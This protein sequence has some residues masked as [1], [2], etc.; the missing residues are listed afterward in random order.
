ML[1]PGQFDVEVVF[2]L[3]H[4]GGQLVVDLGLSETFQQQ[5]SARLLGEAEGAVGVVAVAIAALIEQPGD[6][7][8]HRSVA[9]SR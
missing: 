1:V 4:V 9:G 6:R 8:L 5:Q 3:A 2:A 7:R